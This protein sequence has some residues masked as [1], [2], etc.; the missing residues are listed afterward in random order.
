MNRRQ[1][2]YFLA[3]AEAGSFSRASERLRVAQPALSARIGELEASVGV[4]LFDR[5][6]RGVRLTPHG[7]A[8]LP[9]AEEIQRAFERA[10]RSLQSSEED[11]ATV[12]SLGVTPAIAVT[13]LPAILDVTVIDGQPVE[14]H[15]QQ[16]AGLTLIDLLVQGK[17]DSALIYYNPKRKDVRCI[18][19][20]HDD[21]AIIGPPSVLGQSGKDINLA[22]AAKF[23]LVLDQKSHLTRHVIESAA[24]KK[25][26]EL[27]V[28][29]EVEPLPAKRRFMQ[30]G[31]C[32]INPA[33]AF[34]TELQEG[35]YVARR[36]VAPRIPVT[37]YLLV[38]AKIEPGRCKTILAAVRTGLKAA[39]MLQAAA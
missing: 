12:I 35:T 7:M 14:W 1:I 32:T 4:R 26:I 2:A 5:H 17:I 19:L 30:R 10:E 38:S 16:A 22:E 34:A 15:A 24:A 13:I 37:M 3:V 28:V 6:P 11:N 33:N 9:H 20:F 21:M 36:I 31:C 39:P 8:L 29:A 27:N 23:K 25:N 18:P